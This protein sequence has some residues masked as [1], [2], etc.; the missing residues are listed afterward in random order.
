MIKITQTQALDLIADLCK[1]MQ[2]H[3]A[4]AAAQAIHCVAFEITNMHNDYQA[5]I[6]YANGQ[7]RKINTE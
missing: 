5:L 3:Q 6:E 2:H 7:L 4:A 1:A